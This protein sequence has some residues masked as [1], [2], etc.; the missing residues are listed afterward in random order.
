MTTVKLSG[1][2]N[3]NSP[4]VLYLHDIDNKFI[5]PE[6]TQPVNNVN[7][8]LCII[9]GEKQ[10]SQSWSSQ[11]LTISN[12]THKSAATRVSHFHSIQLGTFDLCPYL[13]IVFI[14]VM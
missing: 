14:P 10:S 3:E 12:V 5:T 11:K 6:E 4:K 9:C 13:T 1:R 8:V 2:L 7:Q